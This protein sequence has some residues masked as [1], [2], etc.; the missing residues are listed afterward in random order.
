MWFRNAM[1]DELQEQPLQQR[2]HFRQIAN[3]MQTI[4]SAH[5]SAHVPVSTTSSVYSKEAA[6]SVQAISVSHALTPRLPTRP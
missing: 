2:Q 3:V 4:Y 6:L 5:S 1:G